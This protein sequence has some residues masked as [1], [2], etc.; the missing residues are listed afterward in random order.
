MR[1]PPHP[2]IGLQTVTWLISGNVLHRDSLGSE[3]LIRPGQLN[4]MT[5]GRGIAHAE[6]S[7]GES[8]AA[9]RGPALGG[10]ARRRRQ[11][12]PAFEHHRGT[13]RAGFPGYG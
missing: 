7:P 1:V 8:R 9:A 13:A 5:A 12:P 2:H 6:E 11:A 10:A 4:L 3:Q